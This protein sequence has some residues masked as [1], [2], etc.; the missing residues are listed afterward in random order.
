MWRIENLRADN[1][2]VYPSI[3]MRIRADAV[4]FYNPLSKAVEAEI[5]DPVL[6]S[7]LQCAINANALGYRDQVAPYVAGDEPWFYLLYGSGITVGTINSKIGPSQINSGG[8]T[9]PILPPGFTSYCPCFPLIL[10]GG[11]TLQPTAPNS[12]VTGI[13]VRGNDVE[14]PNR[15]LILGGGGYPV[16]NFD[17]SPWIPNQW[18]LWTKFL[19][20]AEIHSSAGGAVIAGLVLSVP[21][22]NFENISLYPTGP[23]VWSAQNVS[24]EVALSQ[25]S[26]KFTATFMHSSGVIDNAV[27]DIFVKGYCFAS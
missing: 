11:A 3:A 22:G 12:G 6:L 21:D 2:A 14:Y 19:T 17:L 10:F 4:D 25:T 8:T 27:C 16:Q 26:Q 7:N 18:A 15:P 24:T 13:R 9:G 20:D 1:D 23:S 5:V